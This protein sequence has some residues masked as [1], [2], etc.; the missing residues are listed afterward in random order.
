MNGF[1]LS[2]FAFLEKKEGK[3]SKRSRFDFLNSGKLWFPFVSIVDQLLLVVEK[4]LVEEGRILKVRPFHDC[5]NWTGLLTETTENALG[6][7]NVVFGG[8]SRSVRTRFTLNSDRKGRTGRLA[9][10]TCNAAFFACWVSAQGVFSS[11]H[12]RQRSLFPRVM[13]NVLSY[14]TNHTIKGQSS[15]K[16]TIDYIYR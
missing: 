2:I 6:H 14:P 3:Y 12:R 11:E 5:I 10:F 4:F 13:Q 15:K 16:V 9:Q 7:V 8:S 1:G